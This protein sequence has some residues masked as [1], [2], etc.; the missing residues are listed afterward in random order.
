MS[1]TRI[2]IIYMIKNYF[3][4]SNYVNNITSLNNYKIT[5]KISNKEDILC[6]NKEHKLDKEK[7]KKKTEDTI[8]EISKENESLVEDD[9]MLENMLFNLT[10]K[11]YINNPTDTKI[12]PQVYRDLGIY[13][14]IL[15]KI[16]INYTKAGKI[17]LIHQLFK[18]TDNISLLIHKQNLIKIIHKDK[19]LIKFLSQKLQQYKKYENELIS[20]WSPLSLEAKKLY[21]NVYFDT[22][23]IN[24]LNKYPL[25]IH[26]LNFYYIFIRHFIYYFIQC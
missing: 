12:D 9:D 21:S 25:S 13:D 15:K 2:I 8:K 4:L 6:T 19:Q 1:I 5:S 24:N 18:P 17:Y 16:N 7:Q 10:I 23:Y 3:M 11:N 26:L 22:K 20:I 14:S